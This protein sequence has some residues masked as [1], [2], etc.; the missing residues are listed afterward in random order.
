IVDEHLLL[1]WRVRA[2][3][4][5]LQACGPESVHY[6]AFHHV[7]RTIGS[8]S[9]LYM[10]RLKAVFQAAKE[11]QEGGYLRSVRSF[12]HAELFDDELE[13]A[14]EFLASGY[15]APAAVVARV[16]LETTLRTLCGDCK[17]V[18]EVKSPNGKWLKLEELNIALA[19]AGVY[20]VT[21]QKEVTA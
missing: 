12:V 11:D 7:E 4:L 17:P 18:I 10:Q 5:L 20:T 13:Q 19:K 8:S 3:N 21:V 6:K 1:S 2:R 14:T 15:T 16:V 9:Y